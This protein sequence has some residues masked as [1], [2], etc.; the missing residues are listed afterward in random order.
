MV[1]LR[2]SADQWIPDALVVDLLPA[3]LEIEN[4]NLKHSIQREDVAIDGDPLWRLQERAEVLHEEF[5]DDRYAAAVRLYEGQTT[6]LF[7]LVRAVS[8]G[9]Y[10]VPPPLVESMYQPEIRAIGVTPP[11]I[12]VI[13]EGA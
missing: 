12:R 11:P 8:P 1:H 2:V 6:H 3:G 13:N 10:T 5:R 4:Q 9:T 7:Y